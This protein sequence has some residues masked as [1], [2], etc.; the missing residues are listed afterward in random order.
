[1]NVWR[2]LE[3]FCVFLSGRVRKGRGFIMNPFKIKE[4]G[5]GSLSPWKRKYNELLKSH[6]FLHPWLPFTLKPLT[7]CISTSLILLTRFSQIHPILSVGPCLRLALTIRSVTFLNGILISL[8]PTRYF[9]SCVHYL[10]IKITF[11][12]KL[13]VTKGERAGRDKLGDWN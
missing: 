12:D 13:M 3:R 7:H 2:V 1:M 4:R 8:L 9:H 11:L 5:K 6:T 10:V